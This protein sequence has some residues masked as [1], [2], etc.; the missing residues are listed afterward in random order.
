[1]PCIYCRSNKRPPSLLDILGRIPSSFLPSSLLPNSL[2]PEYPES[3]KKGTLE[4]LKKV[5]PPA[6]PHPY[7][8]YNAKLGLGFLDLW[9][10]RAEARTWLQITFNTHSLPHLHSKGPHK[11]SPEKEEFSR[12]LEQC[13]N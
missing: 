3:R 13:F 10:R 5:Y 1:M 7:P 11:E 8:K 12:G 6:T 9:A 4:S 2:V